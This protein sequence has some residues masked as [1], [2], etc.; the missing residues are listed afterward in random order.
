MNFCANGYSK[1][2]LLSLFTLNIR[3]ELALIKSITSPINTPKWLGLNPL[4]NSFALL[5]YKLPKVI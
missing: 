1:S 4:I 5:L 3:L 2:F